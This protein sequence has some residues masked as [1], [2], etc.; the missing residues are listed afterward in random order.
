MI[1]RVYM[2]LYDNVLYITVPCLAIKLRWLYIYICFI[3]GPTSI[4]FLCLRKCWA[5]V[6]SSETS[7]APHKARRCVL[8]AW[9]KNDKAM[10]S[11][12]S[13]Y[14]QLYPVTSIFEREREWRSLILSKITGFS[15][16]S[17]SQMI[18]FVPRGF[19]DDV[20]LSVSGE[21]NILANLF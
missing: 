16:K 5:D 6:R 10:C 15:C 3:Q 2:I 14:I 19:C 20:F 17:P 12:I 4:H 8:G 13:K 18:L 11:K 9:Q 7:F 21:K 1:S